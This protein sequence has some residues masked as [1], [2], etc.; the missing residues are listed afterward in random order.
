MPLALTS[1]SRTRPIGLVLSRSPRA[2]ALAR[3]VSCSPHTH[4]V[5][6][7][8][9]DASR[10][11]A[12]TSRS[13]TRLTRL[14]LSSHSPRALA[15][16]RHVSCSHTRLTSLVPSHSP[17]TRLT[18]LVPSRS[19]RALALVRH[20]SCSPLTHLVL[21]HS[22]DVSRALALTS[23]SHTRLTRLML[24]HSS[25]MSRAPRA[26]L[27]LSHS[28]NRSRALALTSRSRTRPTRLVPSSHSPR[29]LTLV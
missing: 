28:S 12:F 6:S 19:P 15:L 24:S 7:H 5:L 25:D 26:H 14:V 16:V 8:S 17:R 2:H 29:A 22:S 20:V 11:L 18:R 3:R 21:S 27:V 4:L 13:R 1:C 9:S 10:A 23:R